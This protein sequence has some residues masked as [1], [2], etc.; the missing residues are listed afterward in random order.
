MP[1]WLLPF[2]N[3]LKSNWKVYAVLSLIALQAGTF[4]GWQHTNDL[5]VAERYAHTNDIINFKKAQQDAN[6]NA[7]RI[8]QTLQQE[9]QANA[10]QADARYANLL[11]QYRASIVRYQTAQSAAS[12][13]YY[14]QLPTPQGG[15]GPSASPVVPDSSSSIS[16]TLNDANICAV[17][18]A[19]LQAIHDWAINPPK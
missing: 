7:Q 5:L 4:Y 13:T 1:I 12:P 18:T 15:N 10:S 11:V 17:N 9:A 19:R 6:D 16:I 14:S 3:N 8:K 2:L